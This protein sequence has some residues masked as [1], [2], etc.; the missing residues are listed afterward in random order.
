MPARHHILEPQASEP[1]QHEQAVDLRD[2]RIKVGESLPRRLT[3]RDMCERLGFKSSA[4]YKAVKAGAFDSMEI[5]PQV[6]PK[7]WSG[8]LVQQWLDGQAIRTFGRKRG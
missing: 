7:A 1:Q 2:R 8:V 4:F 5:L 3:A 6:G